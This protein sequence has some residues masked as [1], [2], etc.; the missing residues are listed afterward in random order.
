VLDIPHEVKS[1]ILEYADPLGPWGA[2]GMAEMPFL[3]VAPAISHA[4]HNATG[5]WLNDLPITPDR[6]VKALIAN[7]IS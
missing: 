7:G 5:V 6:V 4:I 1:V 2:R 3:C